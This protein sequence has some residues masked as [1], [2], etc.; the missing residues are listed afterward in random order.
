MLQENLCEWMFLNI[1]KMENWKFFFPCF[2]LV[3]LVQKYNQTKNKNH[4]ASK[5]SKRFKYI[6]KPQHLNTNVTNNNLMFESAQK[7]KI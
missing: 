6:E 7:I 2:N 5:S 3:N 4:A 1:D